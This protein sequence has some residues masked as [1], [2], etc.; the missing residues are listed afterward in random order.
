MHGTFAELCKAAEAELSSFIQQIVVTPDL[1][2]NICDADVNETYLAYVLELNKKVTFSKQESTKM[3][4]ACM[5]MAPELEKLRTKSVQKIREFLLERVS[6]CESAGI[7]RRL[8]LLDPGFGFGKTLEHNLE[9]FRGLP[10]LVGLGL[11]VLIGVSR[12]S[13]IGRILGRDTRQRLAGG[14]ALATLAAQQ[15]VAVVRTHDVRATR[16]VLAMVAAVRKEG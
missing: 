3:T 15:G 5:D 10:G 6:D 16:D 4:S 1:I 11:P 8:L 9:L 13:M 7:P 2:S 14:L 12:K